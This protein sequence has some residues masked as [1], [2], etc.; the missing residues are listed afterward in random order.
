MTLGTQ[1][2]NL[3]LTHTCCDDEPS[4]GYADT[5]KALLEG[6][7]SHLDFLNRQTWTKAPPIDPWERV[8]DGENLLSA[9]LLIHLSGEQIA[10]YPKLKNGIDVFAEHCNWPELPLIT[11]Q[12]QLL[13]MLTE[14]GGRCEPSFTQSGYHPFAKG[15]YWDWADVPFALQHAKLGILHALLAFQSPL[16]KF[17]ESAQAIA[18][19]Q[20][21]LLDEDYTPMPLFQREGTT[22]EG[23]LLAFHYL[24]YKAIAQLRQCPRASSIAEA[25][26]ARLE[27]MTLSLPAFFSVVEAYLTRQLAPPVPKAVPLPAI[28]ADTE[29]LI[30]GFRTAHRTIL[31][32]Q[33]GSR[34]GLGYVRKGDVK[35][36]SYGPQAFPLAECQEFGIEAPASAKHARMQ[37]DEFFINMSNVVKIPLEPPINDH[38]STFG[39]LP[40]PFDYAQIHQE[41]A[42]DILEISFTPHKWKESRDIA[43]VFYVKAFNCLL[44]DGTLIKRKSLDRFEGPSQSLALQAAQSTLTLIPGQ[45]VQQIK[46][47]PLSGEDVYWGADYLISFKLPNSG[48][49]YRWKIT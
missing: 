21:Q 28:I 6:E 27:E 38:P 22:T 23:E 49:L 25:M 44:E 26:R 41:Y 47:I 13:K 31:C 37:V 43:F 7:T 19:W 33:S 9:A 48:C 30:G 34:T 1:L 11:A 16:S 2:L 18:D 45:G 14:S 35:I 4:G 17:E 15:G 36:L 40:P 24:L 46:I 39:M 29:V 42:N 5:L 10:D 3:G 8:L 20:T 12:V 32:A